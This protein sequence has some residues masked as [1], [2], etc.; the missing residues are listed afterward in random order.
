MEN[1]TLKS[2]LR[3]LGKKQYQHVHAVS[4]D[5][6]K[7]DASNPI[8]YFLLAVLAHDHKNF[9]KAEELFKRAEGLNPS[10]PHFPT[11]L[12]RLYAALKRPEDATNAADRASKHTIN[13]AYLADILGVIYS[14]VSYHE[15]AVNLFKKA[16]TID[17]KQSNTFY[18]LGAAELFIGNFEAAKAA[19]VKAIDLDKSHYRAWASL[20]TLDK[21]TQANNK[22]E[23]LKRLYGNLIDNEDAAHQLGHAI[24]KSLEDLGQHEESLEWLHKAKVR[25]RKNYRHNRVA[26]KSAFNAASRTIETK[27]NGFFSSNIPI[28][29]VGLPRTGT[30]LVDR[31]LS[32]HSKIR[33]AGELNFFADII[34]TQT[35]TK[36][37]LVLDAETFE[38]ANKIDLSIAG[39]NYIQRV[40]R[41]LGR[42]PYFIDKMPFNFFYAA[43]I[44]KALPK[45][46]IIALRRGAMDSCL[47]N[48]RQLLSV[49]D[50]FYNYTYD[51][52]DIAFFYKEFDALMAHWREKLP[53]R[54]F[55]EVKYEDIVFDQENQT[56]RLIEF[57]GLEFEEACLDFHENEASVSTASSVQV[58]KP[59]YSGSIGRWK[60]YGNKLD[61]LRAALGNL[62]D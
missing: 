30:T 20:V 49:Q 53:E 58:R 19:F 10:E 1:L 44:F 59:L 6:I 48:Y 25:K 8:P 32:S 46:K 50:S 43:L 21:Q 39:Q 13:D 47:S 11:F 23:L 35:Q 55:I 26:G 16:V 37:N 38:Q 5:A 42:L 27:S 57:C 31:I 29:I 40:Q 24:A 33:S 62:A 4:I 60:K 51:L 52:E 36:S 56:R 3:A 54:S 9:P 18:N 17:D 28:F 45:A 7:K 34:K 12:G 15:K 22:L 2:G 14:R 61:E 41:R